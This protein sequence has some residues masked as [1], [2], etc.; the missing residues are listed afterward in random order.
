MA[1]TYHGVLRLWG[2]K[3]PPSRSSTSVRRSTSQQC[4]SLGNDPNQ[5]GITNPAGVGDL[6]SLS[7]YLLGMGP[8]TSIRGYCLLYPW[9]VSCIVP[10]ALRNTLYGRYWPMVADHCLRYRLQFLG[11]LTV[12]F[13]RASLNVCGR[14]HNRNLD[15]DVP[16]VVAIS[17]SARD[18]LWSVL[19]SLSTSVA[20]LSADTELEP[21]HSFAFFVF[22]NAIQLTG[23]LLFSLAILTALL[24]KKVYRMPT[25]YSFC[26]R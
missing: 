22:W 18:A 16:G 4:T 14:R 10:R 12:L 6:H 5:I 19:A 25:W 15:F 8:Q 2:I 21:R 3:H 7:S 23:G 11:C 1:R 13:V 24:S 9:L 20:Y 26:F 17:T